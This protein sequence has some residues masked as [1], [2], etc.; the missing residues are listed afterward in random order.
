[1]IKF[2]T[3]VLAVGI[4][5]MTGCGFQSK[6]VKNDG[7][8]YGY[9]FSLCSNLPDIADKLKAGLGQSKAC[10][11]SANDILLLPKDYDTNNL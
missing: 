7:Q 5:A 11:R 8:R 4:L 6:I 10:L 2:A 3:V 1:M 9:H